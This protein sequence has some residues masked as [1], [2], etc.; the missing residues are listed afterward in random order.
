MIEILDFIFSGFWIWLG[1]M[2]LVYILTRFI[3]SVLNNFMYH[4]TVRKIGYPPSHCVSQISLKDIKE[5]NEKN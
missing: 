1:F 4:R 2:V 5:N 3:V